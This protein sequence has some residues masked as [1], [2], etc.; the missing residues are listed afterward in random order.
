[1]N[2]NLHEIAPGG[3]H[4]ILSILDMNCEYLAFPN[5]FSKGRFGLHYPPNTNIHMSRYFNQRLPNYTQQ[6]SSNSDFIFYA[7]SVLQQMNF[8]NQISIVMRKMSSVGLNASTFR[9]Y[10]ESVQQFVRND[11]GFL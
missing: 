5:L 9:N 7:E 1:M 4:N 10:K 3:D 2:N 6:F 8:H 11:Q